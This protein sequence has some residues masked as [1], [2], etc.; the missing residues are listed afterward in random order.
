MHNSDHFI[1]LQMSPSSDEV[2]TLKHRFSP[3]LIIILFFLVENLCDLEYKVIL[4]LV[5]FP[6]V[7]YFFPSIVIQ[8]G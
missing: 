6:N 3:A 7:F 2:L 1:D 8:V 5:G 4:L